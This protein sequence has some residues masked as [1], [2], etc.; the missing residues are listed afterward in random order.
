MSGVLPGSA[1]L[2]VNRTVKAP[3]FTKENSEVA[4]VGGGCRDGGVT[5]QH[6][7]CALNVKLWKELAATT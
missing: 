2:V 3:G 5:S 1:F 7:G 4:G 6:G